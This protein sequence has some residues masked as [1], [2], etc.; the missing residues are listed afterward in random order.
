VSTTEVG[1]VDTPEEISAKPV[2][3]DLIGYTPEGEETRETFLFQ[4][5]TPA[6][7]AWD[8]MLASDERGMVPDGPIARYITKAFLNDEQRERFEEFLNSGVGLQANFH[9]QL[10][11]ALISEYAQRPT[12]RP[13]G[14]SGTRPS[15]R[16]TSGAGRRAPA[17]RSTRSR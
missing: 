12:Q 10:Y 3:L 8:V 1:R 16:R 7:A 6:G 2:S 4:P 14:S 5:F 17:S 15:T 9:G 11:Q 13:S